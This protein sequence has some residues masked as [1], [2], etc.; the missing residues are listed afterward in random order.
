ML[1]RKLVAAPFVRMRPVSRA[2]VPAGV[3]VVDELVRLALIADPATSVTLLLLYHTW[4]AGQRARGDRYVLRPPRPHHLPR[5]NVQGIVPFAH[6]LS[7]RFVTVCRMYPRSLPIRKFFDRLF[8]PRDLAADQTSRRISANRANEKE[9]ERDFNFVVLNFNYAPDGKS[10]FRW[11]NVI[12]TFP[13]VYIFYTEIT[14]RRK[15]IK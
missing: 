13:R 7:A 1:D 8:R 6:H 14:F 3:L 5:A 4:L 9:T 11:N 2:A 12:K 15:R 10:L